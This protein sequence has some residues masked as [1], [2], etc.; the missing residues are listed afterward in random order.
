MA[1]MKGASA[2]R[3]SLVSAAHEF[4]LDV[5]PFREP[6]S[7][8]A[9]DAFVARAAGHHV[10]TAVVDAILLRCLAVLNKHTGDPLPSLVESYLARDRGV[11]DQW[12][13]FAAC[14]AD[15]LKYRGVG[16]ISVQQ[17][18][19]IVE[20]QY[21]DPHL[22]LRTL[23][24]LVGR[25][26]AALSAAFKRYTGLTFREYVRRTRLDHAG[27]LLTMTTKSIKEVWSQVGYNYGSNF[28][29]DF[30]RRFGTSPRDYRARA[31]HPMMSELADEAGMADEALATTSP[32]EQAIVLMVD[33]GGS[34]D[35]PHPAS[36]QH[37]RQEGYALFTASSGAEAL[38]EIDRV[39][40]DVVLLE[41]HLPDMSGLECLRTLRH[42]H[43]TLPAVAFFTADWDAYDETDAIHALNAVI[44]SKLCDL[45]DL[46]DLIVRLLRTI[47]VHVDVTDAEPAG[48]PVS[49]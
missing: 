25:R 31:I 1:S 2:L 42:T 13:R 26:P 27:K 10:A 24:A 43:P 34:G 30:K 18:I 11:D 22:A 36:A 23:A 17:A 21:N 48:T 4:L 41:Y 47:E 20:K 6:E 45:D 37:L 14:V 33:G 44:A 19:A 7:G 3:F 15:G 29:H 16:D 49:R 32:H 35:G 40:P 8:A 12:T 28:D 39:S 38:R 5:L 9:L 46:K